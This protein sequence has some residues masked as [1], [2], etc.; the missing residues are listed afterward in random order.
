MGR[1]VAGYDV[2]GAVGQAQKYRFAVG[3]RPQRR[4]HF[5]VGVVGHEVVIGKRDIVRAG[6]T[7][8]QDPEFFRVA[9]K[10]H[11]PGG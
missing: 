5:P 3:L 6:F 11:R 7:G 4:V 9:H 2:D 10:A 8:D 1:V